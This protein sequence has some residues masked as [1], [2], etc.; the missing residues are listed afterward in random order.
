ML[1]VRSSE[2]Y[3]ACNWLSMQRWKTIVLRLDRKNRINERNE[4]KSGKIYSIL[5]GMSHFIPSQK[6]KF[7]NL[8]KIRMVR[9]I[10]IK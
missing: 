3:F 4:I 6:I 7:T 2:L 5:T 1:L 10:L 9:F 8:E